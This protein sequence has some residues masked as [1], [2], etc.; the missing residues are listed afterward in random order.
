MAILYEDIP[1][2][3]KLMFN[4]EHP[5]NPRVYSLENMSPLHLACREADLEIVELVYSRIKSLELKESIDSIMSEDNEESR[6]FNSL[7]MLIG[8]KTVSTYPKHVSSLMK[9]L[10]K[11]AKEMDPLNYRFV[12]TIIDKKF[13]KA[14]GETDLK[15]KGHLDKAG[16]EKFTCLHLACK[17]GRVD[18]VE[19][20]LYN[21]ADQNLRTMERETALHISAHKGHTEVVKKLVEAGCPVEAKN[22]A[23]E[24]AMH[25]AAKADQTEVIQYLSDK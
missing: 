11:K 16:E 14:M 21:G 8:V 22:I 18:V 19:F 12:K 3:K 17:D 9:Q 4:K 7:C 5:C 1:C 20:I 2:I 25:E 23:G 24:T 10:H 6:Q 15:M 13:K